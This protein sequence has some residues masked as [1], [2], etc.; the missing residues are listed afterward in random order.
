MKL[1]CIKDTKPKGWRQIETKVPGIT[2]GKV[3]DGIFYGSGQ[4][5]QLTLVIWSDENKWEDVGSYLIDNFK[6][7]E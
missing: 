6:P 4:F 5:G 3:Y 7:A 1:L 2:A